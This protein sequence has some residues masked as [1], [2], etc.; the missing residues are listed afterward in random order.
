MSTK[1]QKFIPDD[2]DVLTF[3]ARAVDVVH[4]S[5][6]VPAAQPLP[7]SIDSV[8][9]TIDLNCRHSLAQ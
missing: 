6:I 1:I 8:Q 3:A 9:W 2:L 7:S 5:F 4:E